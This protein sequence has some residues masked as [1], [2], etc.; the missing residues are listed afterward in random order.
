MTKDEYDDLQPGDVIALNSGGPLMTVK[1]L[2]EKEGRVS[3]LRICKPDLSNTVQ[4][5]FPFQMV[6]KIKVRY[7]I[8]SKTIVT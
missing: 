5:G 2:D 4:E 1:D 3:T 7:I 8:Y 6:Q